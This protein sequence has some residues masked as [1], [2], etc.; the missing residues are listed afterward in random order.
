MHDL[1]MHVRSLRL[2]VGPLGCHNS[3]AALRNVYSAFKFRESASIVPSSCDLFILLRSHD[4]PRDSLQRKCSATCSPSAAGIMS[5]TGKF[6]CHL[7]CVACR[8]QKGLALTGHRCVPQA[9]VAVQQCS[10][11]ASAFLS[12]SPRLSGCCA[13]RQ[14][15]L[16]GAQIATLPR[17]QCIELTPGN[18]VSRWKS[19]AAAVT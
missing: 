14:R 12:S 11:R 7:G 10:H 5:T 3:C 17:H 6:E 4:L 19:E 9:A 1:C 8:A 2:R 16:A 18:A 15:R 13:Q